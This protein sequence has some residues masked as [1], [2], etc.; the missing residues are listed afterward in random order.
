MP[1]VLMKIRVVWISAEGAQEIASAAVGTLVERHKVFYSEAEQRLNT[2]VRYA[3]E[4][5]RPIPISS[6]IDAFDIEPT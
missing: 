4:V 5:L 1:R 3:K 2:M 6:G